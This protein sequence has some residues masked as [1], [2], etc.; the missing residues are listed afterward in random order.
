MDPQST[1]RN[2]PYTACHECDLLLLE[3]HPAP[4]QKALCPRCGS[5]LAQ[6]HH[7]SIHHGLA[8]CL[9]GLLL[10]YPAQFLPVLDLNILGQR[11]SASVYDGVQILLSGE[12]LLVGVLVFL[13]AMAIPLTKLLLLGFCLLS[14]LGTGHNRQ[15]RILALQLFRWYHGLRHWGMLEIYLLGILVS[16]IKLMDMA[17]LHFGV[18]FYALAGLM[19]VSILLDVKLDEHGIWEQLD[20]APSP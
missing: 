8:L 4:G 9:A 1:Q 14:T 16:V 11:N 17:E 7:D 6:G 10:F 3:P 20:Q 13:C 2:E 18:G 19:L 15:D 5:V 12:Y